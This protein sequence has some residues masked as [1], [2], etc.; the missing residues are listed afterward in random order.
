MKVVLGA[1]AAVMLF[2]GVALAQT[3][4]VAPAGPPVQSR[5]GEVEAEPSIPDGAVATNRAI[6]AANDAYIAWGTAARAV[7]EC[8]RAEVAELDARSHALLEQHNAA[9]GR[10]NALTAT[11]VAEQQEY[12]ARDGV[13]CEEVAQ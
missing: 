13:T 2:A 1:A 7:L 4:G 5:C 9:V 6:N 3:E 10:V 12:C 11:W 8:R